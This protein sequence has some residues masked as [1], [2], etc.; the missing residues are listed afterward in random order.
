MQPRRFVV[1]AYLR[2]VDGARRVC[3]A[4]LES[5]LMPLILE[6][7]SGL[8]CSGAGLRQPPFPLF[9]SRRRC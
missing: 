3:S 5:W 7:T 4:I 8:L 6:H 9:Y 2:T 1:S